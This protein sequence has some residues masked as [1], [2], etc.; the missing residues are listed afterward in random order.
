MLAVIDIEPLVDA[1]KSHSWVAAVVA[2]VAV[3]GAVLSK[4]GVVDALK[5]KL[6]MAPAPA[7]APADPAK[8]D[9]QKA[10]DLLDGKK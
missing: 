1:L 4:L 7:P 3:V 6:G 5:A 10:Q 8:S 2:G 9:A